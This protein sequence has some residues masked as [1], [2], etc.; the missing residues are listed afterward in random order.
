M[1]ATPVDDGP[2]NPQETPIGSPS[3]RKGLQTKTKDNDITTT[4]SDDDLDLAPRE[5]RNPP[6][7]DHTKMGRK[8]GLLGN[9]NKGEV[10]TAESSTDTASIQ[11]EHK[12]DSPVVRP[13]EVSLTVDSP[14]NRLGKIGGRHKNDDVIHATVKRT[15]DVPPGDIFTKDQLSPRSGRT[16]RKASISAP[17]IRET[18][19][20]RADRKRAQL[21]QE[22]E[23]KSKGPVK[24][25]RRF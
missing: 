6:H 2:Q 5:V 10:I 7:S 25:K 3:H 15:V 21:E 11:Q 20:E 13:D 4:E 9:R 18:S 24:K 16:P 22:L 23:E 14:K 1:Q 12:A 19:H 17:S 8:I